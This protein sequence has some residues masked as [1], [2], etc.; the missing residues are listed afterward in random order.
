MDGRDFWRRGHRPDGQL[1]GFVHPS[2]R[3]LA[4]MQADNGNSQPFCIHR[5]IA[6][7]RRFA[8]KR[9]EARTWGGVGDY[10]FPSLVSFAG[11][12]EAGKVSDFRFFGLWQSLTEANDFRS[13][14]AH[15]VCITDEPGKFKMEEKLSSYLSF[16][17][18][19]PNILP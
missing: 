8:K 7:R 15:A 4:K 6:F 12:E 1:D 11:E 18:V 17:A 14:N 3:K 9:L 5:F 13:F 19:C 2:R 10:L 16:E